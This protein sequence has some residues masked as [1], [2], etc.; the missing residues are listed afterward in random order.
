MAEKV[1]ITFGGGG[2]SVESLLEQAEAAFAEKEFGVAIGAFQSVLEIDQN[3][4]KAVDPVS[5]RILNVRLGVIR[6]SQPRSH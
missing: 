3:N 6:F 4:E 1:L 2:K 5:C